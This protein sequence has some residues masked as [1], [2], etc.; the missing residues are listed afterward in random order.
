MCHL[1]NFIR[2]EW[3]LLYSSYSIKIIWRKSCF[4]FSFCQF[5]IS[6]YELLT[7]PTCLK[8]RKLKENGILWIWNAAW[9]ISHF[10]HVFLCWRT[11]M[12]YCVSE[13]KRFTSLREHSCIH[14]L[15]RHASER[16]DYITESVKLLMRPT[17]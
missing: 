15:S 7:L 16:R 9:H 11:Y 8:Y 3:H 17:V 13:V 1:I 4:L 5:K 14:H 12:L 6:N 2:S 10:L